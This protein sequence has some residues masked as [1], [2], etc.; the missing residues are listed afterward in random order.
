MIIITT[1]ENMPSDFVLLAQN[2]QT[3][4]MCGTTDQEGYTVVEDIPEGY[5]QRCLP[6]GTGRYL[7]MQ[8][9]INCRARKF[10]A[11]TDWQVLRHSDQIALGMPTS[12]TEQE[13][14]DLLQQR[15]AARDSVSTQ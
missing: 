14:A 1:P 6:D 4:E 12:L 3:Y 9:I 10:L 11:D 5:E 13:Y 2:T 15:Q 7:K 8:D